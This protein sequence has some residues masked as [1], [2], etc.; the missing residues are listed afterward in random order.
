MLKKICTICKKKKPI[1]E[2]HKAKKGK[3]GVRGE[4]AQCY[5]DKQEQAKIMPSYWVPK[6]GDCFR[7]FIDGIEPQ[8]EHIGSP[9]VC[10]AREKAFIAATDKHNFRVHLYHG[11]YRFSKVN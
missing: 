6:T 7:A 9:F 10:T 5:H 11:L 4:C 3:Y 2:F 8:H 1:S